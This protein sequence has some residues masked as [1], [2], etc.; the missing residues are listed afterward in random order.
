ML[1][2]QIVLLSAPQTCLITQIVV[3]KRLA[4]SKFASV[5]WIVTP[6]PQT[7]FAGS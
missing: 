7:G 1:Q 4:D 3:H 2:E 5:L 6:W